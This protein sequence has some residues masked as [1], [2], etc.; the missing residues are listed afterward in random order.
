MG[1]LVRLNDMVG[2]LVGNLV[3]VT[4][5][6]CVIVGVV[7]GVTVFVGVHASHI[8]HP[9]DGDVDI[10]IEGVANGMNPS[11]KSMLCSCFSF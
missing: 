10:V 9:T 1:V 2:V 11:P 5:I 6:L 4:V 7:V 8:S 3:P